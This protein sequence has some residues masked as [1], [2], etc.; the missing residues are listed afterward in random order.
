MSQ[1]STA[2]KT[3][4]LETYLRYGKISFEKKDVLI[5][6][7]IWRPPEKEEKRLEHDWKE[8]RIAKLTIY[9]DDN[10]EMREADVKSLTIRDYCSIS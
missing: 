1:A 6:D 2:R 4:K 7:G 10:G 5:W 3:V 9:V 8:R